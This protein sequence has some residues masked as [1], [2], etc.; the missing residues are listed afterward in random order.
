MMIGAKLEMAEGGIPAD[1]KTLA[2]EELNAI[3]PDGV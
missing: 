1:A 2:I 3:A